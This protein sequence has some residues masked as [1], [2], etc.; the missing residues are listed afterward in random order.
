MTVKNS[1]VAG[2]RLSVSRR[3]RSVDNAIRP[4][5]E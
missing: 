5:R 4:Q 3:K 1:P 2:F